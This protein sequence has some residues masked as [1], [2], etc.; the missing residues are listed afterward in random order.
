VL[1]VLVA[2]PWIER[3]VTGDHRPHHVLGRPRDAPGRTALGL[4]FLS[5]VFL[6]FVAG[7]ADRAT[8]FFGLEYVDPVWFYRV[9]IW[10]VPVLVFFVTRRAC[11]G[12]QAIERADRRSEEAQP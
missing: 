2:F 6:V 8:V 4:A 3:R 9:A 11:R 1:L 10:I 12:L 5:W 7:S